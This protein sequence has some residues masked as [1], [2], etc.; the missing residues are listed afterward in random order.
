MQPSLKTGL[1]FGLTS[2]VITTL[3]LVVGLHAGTHSEL[4]VIG[5]ILT[6][7]VADALSDA[8]GIHVS[9]EAEDIYLTRELWVATAATFVVK[10]VIAVTFLVPVLFLTL[11]GAI[12]VSVVWGL[13][14]LAAL[15]YWIARSRHVAPSRVV[16]EHLVLAGAV[17]VITHFL[18]DWVHRY[19]GPL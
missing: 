13:G 14:L 5:G 11:P 15:S 8:M 16:L 19:F 10:L 17:V 18:G 6:I 3:G 9:R 4:A 2:G 7:A 1:H 12:V